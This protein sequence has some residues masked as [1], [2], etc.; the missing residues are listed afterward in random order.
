MSSQ[1][2]NTELLDLSVKLGFR[3]FIH[4]IITP[5]EE[6]SATGYYGGVYIRETLVDTIRRYPRHDKFVVIE[7]VD[8]EYYLWYIHNWNSSNREKEIRRRQF[9]IEQRTRDEKVNRVTRSIE[10]LMQ[11]Y[12]RLRKHKDIALDLINNWLSDVEAHESEL[13]QIAHFEPN[14][15]YESAVTNL[16]MDLEEFQD[17]SK[18][19]PEMCSG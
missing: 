2:A 4:A 8:E 18:R 19:K 17:K 10:N 14:E 3:E 13:K 15:E 12:P 7:R 5:R 16:Q 11:L 6:Y 9:E 1:H